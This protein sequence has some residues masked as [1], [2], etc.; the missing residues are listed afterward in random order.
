ML[1]QNFKSRKELGLSSKE[2]DALVKVLAMLERGEIKDE[3]F[4]MGTT[5]SVAINDFQEPTCQSPACICGWARFVAG[6]HIF[7]LSSFEERG[8]GELFLMGAVNTARRNHAAITLRP[9]HAAIALRNYLT[10]GRPLWHEALAEAPTTAASPGR[11][12]GPRSRR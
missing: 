5:G 2:F 7:S 12:R 8:L 9:A 6:D 4:D 1:A 11:Y 3:A 10:H